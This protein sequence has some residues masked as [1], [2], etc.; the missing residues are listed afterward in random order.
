VKVIDSVQKSPVEDPVGAKYAM[1]APV[2][3]ATLHSLK[4]DRI[5]RLGG[6]EKVTV[7]DLARER[8]EGSGDA[9][10]CFEYAVHQAIA[11]RSELI[12]P[13]AC[14]VL[15]E[16]CKIPGTA[17][18]IFFGPEKNGRIPVL[19]TAQDALTDDAVLYTGEPGRPPKLKQHLPTIVKAFHNQQ[20][21]WKLPWSIDGVWKADLFLGVV[22]S[23]KWVATTVKIN[24][25]HLESGLGLR[26]GIY[27][28]REARDR[29]RLDYGLNLIR[30]PLPYDQAFMELFYRSF[31]LARAFLLSD[32]KVPP[33]A[34]LYAAEDRYVADWLMQRRELPVL[35]VIKALRKLSQPGL[36]VTDAIENIQPSAFLSEE[37]EIIK[38]DGGAQP[39]DDI[40]L[41]PRPDIVRFK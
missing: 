4:L 20:E 32:A 33:P 12:H 40:T 15:E 39:S 28:Q 10:I 18:S 22:R 37:G 14:E 13:L 35:E 16:F 9:G 6:L 24:E 31:H 2:L 3:E 23:Q 34:E 1:L 17:Q 11:Q 19:E 5:E 29:P 38:G 26:L 8:R 36:L 27:P 25:R 41:A 21:R 7:Y 30:L